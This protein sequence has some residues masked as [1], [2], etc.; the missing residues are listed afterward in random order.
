MPANVPRENHLTLYAETLWI[1]PYVFSSFVALRAKGVPF[2]IEEVA[3]IHDAHHAPAYRDASITAR[4]PALVHDGFWLAESSAIADYLEDVLPPPRYP[5]LLPA[6]P[7]AR[8]RARQIMAWLRS[9]LGALRDERPTTTM[10]YERAT[11]PL[12]PAGAQAARKLVRVAERLLAH[13]RRS[14]FG[15]W[16]LADSELAFMLH[17]LILNGHAV[18]PRVQAFA[19]EEWRRPAAQEFVRHRRPATVPAEYWSTSWN[20][21]FAGMPAAASPGAAEKA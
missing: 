9:D 3:L 21:P 10:F 13:D 11:T 12:S 8:A 19:E 17:R 15:V 20:A 14:L 2:D 16:S 5:A 1:S 18:P 4:V 7:R 6:D